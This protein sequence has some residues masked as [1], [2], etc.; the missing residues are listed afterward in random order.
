MALTSVG[1]LGL[2]ATP[3]GNLVESAGAGN[4]RAFAGGDGSVGA[5]YQISDVDQLQDMSSDL[6]A[7][8]L[9]INDVDAS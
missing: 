1:L 9:L 2:L 6:S 7:H 3:S 8:Y 4:T 5:P